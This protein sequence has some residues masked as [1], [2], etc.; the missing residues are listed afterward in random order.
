MK[1][2][3]Q[4]MSLIFKG[5]TIIIMIKYHE[6]RTPMGMHIMFGI[7]PWQVRYKLSFHKE[8]QK[9]FTSSYICFIFA[10]VFQKYVAARY[11]TAKCHVGIT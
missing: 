3:L 5:N 7:L 8:V 4:C 1:F 6:L 10:F 9:I 11:L 2:K